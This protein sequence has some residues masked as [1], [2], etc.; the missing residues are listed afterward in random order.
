MYF[1]DLIVKLVFLSL[2]K[3][4]KKQFSM[5]KKYIY[6]LSALMLLFSARGNAQANQFERLQFTS[7]FNEDVIA[8]G[9]GPVHESTT[10]MIDNDSFNLHSLD[11]KA[12]ATSPAA[13]VGLPVS[14]LINASN[15]AGLSFQLQPYSQP[16]SVRIGY[17]GTS[18]TLVVSNQQKASKI[19]LLVTSGNAGNVPVVFSAK[20]HF[21]DNSFQEVTRLSAPDWYSGTA[22]ITV[23]S[24]FGRV[25]VFT[26][27]IETPLGNPKLFSA[28]LNLNNENRNK[29][30]HSIEIM[31][32][33]SAEGIL[34]VFAA[35]VQKVADCMAP[36]TVSVTNI[37]Q[38][39]ATLRWLAPASLPSLG[40]Q[41]EVRT[42]GQPGSGVLGLFASGHVANNVLFQDITGL[43]TST[44][45]KVYVRAQ[46]SSSSFSLWTAAFTFS[47]LCGYPELTAS[48][49]T[50]CKGSAA[51]LFASVPEGS[52][53]WF[54]SEVGGQVLGSENSLVTPALDETKSYWVS[55]LGADSFSGYGGK[56]APA[57]DGVGVTLANWGIV[58]N[59]STEVT[60]E[61]VDV[62]STS[63]GILRVKITDHTGAELFATPNI[64]ILN[65]GTTTPNVIPLGF[66]LPAGTGYRMLVKN[67]TD[68]GLI[69]ETDANVS[70]P[71]LGEGSVLTV[72]AGWWDPEIT[73]RYYYFYNIRYSSGCQSPRKKVV[74][75]VVA[76]PDFELST[77]RVILDCEATPS[78]A[79][80]ITTGRDSFDSYV[81]SPSTGVSGDPQTGWIF[82]PNRNQ[83]YTLTARQST[84]LNCTVVKQ[85][86]VLGKTVPTAAYIPENTLDAVCRTAIIP[87]EVAI[88]DEEQNI[89]EV[90]VGQDVSTTFNNNLSA[91]NNNRN[92]V[93][94][95]L[96]FTAAELRNWGL[97]RGSIYSLA[98][99]VSSLGSSANNTNY[100]VKMAHTDLSLFTSATFSNDTFTEVYYKGS[101]GHTASGWQQINFDRPFYWD[102]VRNLIIELT[103]GGSNG[104]A[105]AETHYTATTE[106][107]VVFGYNNGNIA[108][109][110]NRFNVN[111]TQK[112]LYHIKWE[113][114]GGGLYIDAAA[115]IPYLP[116]VN[117]SRVYYRPTQ[118]DLNTVTAFVGLRECYTSHDF[119][120]H[121]VET[122]PVEIEP[123]RFICG[124]QRISDFGVR[125]HDIKWYETETGGQPLVP[126]TILEEQSY[127]LTQTMDGCES[128]RTK[129]D[130]RFYF[131]PV[132]PKY[133]A[134]AF[135]CGTVYIDDLA[136]EYNRANT[137]NWYDEH[138][139]LI[140]TNERVRTG[141]YYITQSNTDC[142]S[143]R[144]TVSI[145]VSPIPAAPITRHLVY[146]RAVRIADTNMPVEQGA[147]AHWYSSPTSILPLGPHQIVTTGTY[148]VSQKRNGCESER[149]AMTVEV[150]PQ[151]ASPVAENQ[152]FCN[153]AVVR[154]SNLIV[155]ET[156]PDAIVQW[157]TAASGG[158]PLT[159]NQ[160][161]SRGFYYVSQKVGPC[162]SARVQ[163]WVDVVANNTAPNIVI[164]Q[165]CGTATVS[166]LRANL[167]E[168][169]VAKWYTQSAGGIALA[170]GAELQS[171][172]YYASQSLNGCESPRKRVEV[173]IDEIPLPP[174]GNAYQQFV[175]GSLIGDLIVD[176]EH[177]VWFGTM[178]DAVN[179]RNRLQNDYPLFDNTIYYGVVISEAGCLSAVFQVKVQLTLSL[180]TFDLKQLSYFPN[181]VNDILNIGYK[182]LIT[183][184]EVYS[185]AGQRVLA[186][187]TA[188]YTVDIDMGNLAKAPYFVKIFTADQQQIIKV[189]KK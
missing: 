139:N 174:T 185:L 102:G 45:Y 41:Y 127:Y 71:Y 146:C 10:A 100:I 61:S 173:V 141:V 124:Q 111:F 130:I 177:V 21:T 80:T 157:F 90:Q 122:P 46:C 106:N 36:H 176:Q 181:P 17:S 1:F 131:Q 50:V 143:E 32:T 123:L 19:Y 7:G 59:L 35:T 73:S 29:L 187:E 3:K 4:L 179:N 58:F 11:F 6:F 42:S 180:N 142:E 109:S 152:I 44:E 168:G 38:Q 154:V 145:T 97:E 158:E 92:R 147:V 167:P 51:T 186:K 76:G 43:G 120:I 189:L 112:I 53:R 128:L 47:T 95:Q 84:G 54:D 82:T 156:L 103:H 12:T 101:H 132:P 110:K 118:V 24:G 88:D 30:I 116:N 79:V 31:K 99:F 126:S 8:N 107:R 67:Y 66:T 114:Q 9:T 5:K 69:R 117:T 74:A 68:T 149:V 23:A 16:N 28:E 94:V 172:W 161:V 85:V 83:T 164:Q 49:V 26:D 144:T 115:T 137:L 48:D 15:I 64:T 125:G 40:Y 75:N 77:D 27:E 56:R 13:P 134:N 153:Q 20:V 105:S 87:L 162:E 159:A 62:Y 133:L 155:G 166:Q 160:L 148:Y 52:V 150:F 89:N 165:F 104:S 113:D 18:L 182:D 138:N 37:V 178:A 72:P 65:G 14:G 171:G 121:V 78:E 151:L 129:M 86:R 175:E 169:M 2:S 91:F 184:I 136:V 60:L 25:S 93:Q 108:L 57:A 39:G 163:V 96:L 119:N 70:F 188:A 98:F 183:K 33:S 63:N 140:T 22:A 55:A 34:N 170:M 81:W 135:V